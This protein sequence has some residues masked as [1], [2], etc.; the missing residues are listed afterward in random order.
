MNSENIQ[1][2]LSKNDF[3]DLERIV[4]STLPKEFIEHYM[5]YNGGS[6]TEELAEANPSPLHGFN[7]IKYGALSI[8][9]LLKD[10]AEQNIYFGKKIPFA[11]DA[12]G[13]LFVLSLEDDDTYGKVFFIGHEFVSEQNYEFVSDSFTEFVNQ[14]AV[15]IRQ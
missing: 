8:E 14:Y 9:T 2:K 1:K 5:K 15:W 10:Y 11:Y 4:G 13:N 7:S 6:P 12:G 3:V